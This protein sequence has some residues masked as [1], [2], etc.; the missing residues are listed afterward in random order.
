MQ[1]DLEHDTNRRSTTDNRKEINAAEQ[2]VGKC[3]FG[4]ER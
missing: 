2:L 1:D 3:I 4:Q